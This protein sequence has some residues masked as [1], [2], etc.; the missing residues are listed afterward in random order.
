MVKKLRLSD[1]SKRI[2]LFGIIIVLGGI[3]PGKTIAQQLQMN[4]VASEF[5]K[6]T[7]ASIQEMFYKT[8][9]EKRISLELEELSLK[10]ALREVASV[11]G[12]KLTY[13][14]DIIP[15]KKVTL[16]SKSIAISDALDHMLAETGLD[17]QFSQEGYLLIKSAE[18]ITEST[19]Y[20]QSISGV[21]VDAMDGTPIPAVNVVVVGSEESMGGVI[22]TTTNVDGEF[23]LD[24]PDDLNTLLITSIGYVEQRVDINGETSFTIELVRATE[25]L[26]DIVVVGYGMQRQERVTGSISSVRSDEL[27]EQPISD[28]STALQ[29]RAS[30]VEIV[31]S[32]GDPG[33]SGAIRIRGTGTVNNADPLIVID[34]M[35]SDLRS[36][37]NINSDNVQSIDVLKDASSAAIY[38]NRAANGVILVTT[39]SGQLD[40]PL[41]VKFN[42]SIGFSQPVNTI[43]VLDAPT[44][45]QLKS[46]RYTNDGI[47]VN[48]IWQDPQY[49]TQR[50]D[51]QDELLGTGTIQD[52]SL[53]LQGGNS[54]SSF[55]VSGNYMDEQGMMESSYF[56]RYGLKINSTHNVSEKLNI[57][58]NLTLSRTSGNTLNT[59]SAQTGVLW[60]A[61][62]F[63]PGLPV[64]Y[65]DGTYSSSQISGEFGDINNPIFTVEQD[66][67][68]E[69]EYRRILGNVQAEYNILPGLSA[70][71][72][73]GLDYSLQDFYTYN[74]IID[75]QIRARSRNSLD[76]RFTENRSILTEA[77]LD[78]SNSIGE[79]HDIDAL[80]GIVLEKFQGETFRA[81]RL[82]FTDESESQRVLDAGNTINL[83]DGTTFEDAL[84]SYLGRVNYAYA[85]KYLLTA[86]LRYDGSSRFS[87]DNRWG[88]FPAFSAGWRI[89]EES[90]F[91]GLRSTIN[92]MRLTAGWG[93]SG[94]QS[95]ARNQFL[96]LYGQNSQYSFNGVQVR[97]ISQTRIPNRDIS[98]ET[99]EMLNFGLHTRWLNDRV[100]ATIEYF[101]K[102]SKDV[103]LAPPILGTLGTATVPDV[104]V[105]EIRNKGFE[106]EIGYS[107]VVGEF[108]YNVT[109]NASFIKNEVTNLND[110]FLSSRRYGRPNAEISRTFEG[111]PIATF[112]GWKTDGLYQNQQEIDSDPNISNDSRQD[113]IQPGDVRFLD[114]NG[115][116]QITGE[117][118]AILGS[119][120]PDMT[121]GLS[122]TSG[123]KN[124]SLNLHFAGAAGV[125]IYNADR[126]QGLDPTY[127]FNMYA[128]VENRWNGQGTSNSIPRMTTLRD[129]QNH[130]TSDLF[131]ENGNYL[132]LKSLTLGYEMPAE[133]NSFLGTRGLRLYVTGINVFTVTPYSGIDPE[134]GYTDGNLQR[135]VDFAQYPQPRTWTFGL[136][137]D[138]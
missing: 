43:D 89:S 14:G 39:K 69:S 71:G 33:A 7:L 76:R 116:G 91:D 94:N 19:V 6:T 13:R 56:D 5:H 48:P 10:Q 58:Q 129:N 117:D 96:G 78:Y 38:G 4:N 77:F 46:E 92:N 121:Y 127:P 15:D 67:D 16:M 119:P 30:G 112:Y 25:L 131:I 23:E 103:L 47:P 98:W 3:L 61:I 70:R 132:R 53:S 80:G 20:V 81:N 51:W 101:V 62:R 66:S 137:I 82:D 65:D 24:V 32:G 41:Q 95:I 60:S 68:S 8:R 99:V 123:Y 36:L 105:G 102:D 27:D 40:Q 49:Q 57:R 107:G 138:F 64:K 11:T 28:L 31:R 75:G 55:Y 37:N 124:F 126:M 111:E 2:C 109:G 110:D 134:L 128:E 50:T 29:G 104:N 108:N 73:L 113:I 72:N 12:M 136:T 125:E 86:S 118:R 1:V 93:R 106:I 83:A 9:F 22:G 18:T 34:G 85:D 114:L 90:F 21:I 42:S 84:L 26:D 45:A 88:L 135:N 44:L 97:G 100:N 63:H 120:H 130:R 59:Q 87:S 35:P 79:N 17:Y 122:V 52:Y 54:T 74:I 115:D 133:V